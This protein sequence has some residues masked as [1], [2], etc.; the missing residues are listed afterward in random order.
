MVAR[1]VRD[2]WNA[3]KGSMWGRLVATVFVT[4]VVVLLGSGQIP[5]W[6]MTLGFVILA[7]MGELYLEFLSWRQRKTGDEWLVLTL[8]DWVV[9]V[10]VFSALVCIVGLLIML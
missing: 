10:A 4:A 3:L 2:I 6:R 9:M 7:A 5:P 1:L 8:W